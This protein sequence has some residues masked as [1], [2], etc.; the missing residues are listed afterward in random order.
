M[1]AKAAAAVILSVSLLS[2]HSLNVPADNPS[3]ALLHS[4]AER[5]ASGNTGI[6]SR[7][8]SSTTRA[9]LN[10][11][12]RQLYDMIMRSRKE[13]GLPVIPVSKSLSLVAKLHVH[14]LE[15]HTVPAPYNF[16]S[17]SKDGPWTS[18]NYTPDHR[19]AK[20]MWDKPR[21]VTQYK[22]NGYEIAYMHSKSATPEAAFHGWT[23]SGSHN[24]VILNESDWRR[25]QWKAIGIGIFGRYASVW[26]GE[27]PDSGT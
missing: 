1:N 8:G 3:V 15:T 11:A 7:I 6:E 23:S 21:E 14:D 18:V 24:S 19:Y 4:S 25:I 9:E 26:F 17:W 10:D 22:G 12:E 16:H 20:L 27:E 2:C 5:S 13:K